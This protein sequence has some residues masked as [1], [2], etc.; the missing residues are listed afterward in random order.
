MDL[1][2][3]TSLRRSSIVLHNKRS[4]R[5]FLYS[6]LVRFSRFATSAYALCVVR[7]L[8]N[9]RNCLE[10]RRASRRRRQFSYIARRLDRTNMIIHAHASR[11]ERV[12]PE[13]KRLRHNQIQTVKKCTDSAIRFSRSEFD[14]VSTVLLPS[15]QQRYVRKTLSTRMRISF[16]CSIKKRDG[17]NSGELF[18]HGLVIFKKIPLNYLKLN[19]RVCTYFTK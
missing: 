7:S 19:F 5:C 4:F 3:L 11:L 2:D 9:S 10:V 15:V 14:F 12:Q 13:A 16:I 17:M 1:R 6:I 8:R 18:E